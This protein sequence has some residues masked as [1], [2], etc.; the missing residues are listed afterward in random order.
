MKTIYLIETSYDW[1]EFGKKLNWE[2]LYAERTLQSAQREMIILRKEE[3]KR[4]E[5][6]RKKYGKLLY[7]QYYR[8]RTVQL[9]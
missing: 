8:Y 4:R 2:C 3:E 6:N 7:Y 1:K 9:Y 5:E